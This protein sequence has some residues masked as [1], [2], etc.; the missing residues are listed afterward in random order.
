MTKKTLIKHIGTIVSGDL[1]RPLP[2]GDTIC[3]SGDKISYIGDESGA[4]PQDYD[5]EIDA[6]GLTVTPGLIDADTNP[7]LANYLAEFKAYD[8]VDNYAAAGI[9]GMVATGAGDLPGLEADRVSA[10]AFALAGKYFWDACH[11]CGVKVHGGPLILTED[12]EEEDFARLAGAG[13]RLVAKIGLAGVRCPEKAA[14]L[15]E[16]A[17]KQ[18]MK[19]ALRCGGPLKKGGR[20]Y[21]LEEIQRI[22]PDILCGINGSPTPPPEEEAKELV[23]SGRYYFNTVSNGNQAFL[24]KAADWAMEAGVLDKMM[25]GTNVPS[26][27]GFS[28]M[29]LWIQMACCCQMAGLKPEQAVAMATGNVAKCYG[30]DHGLLQTGYKADLLFADTGSV[31][32][33][34]LGTLGYGRVPS[35]AGTI[36]NGE[37]TLTRCRNTAPPSKRPVLTKRR[38]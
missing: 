30:L 17:K 37:F 8:W 27:S 10:M 24:V 2:Q 22:S 19:A 4:P 21:H 7:P 23:Q 20:Y 11:P 3:I 25:L 29:G 12:M 1:D 14:G 15:V 31:M 6:R 33:D 16:K 18:G 9:T 36:V 38:A 35:A 32:P 13:I 34:L 5:L 26:V 28:P